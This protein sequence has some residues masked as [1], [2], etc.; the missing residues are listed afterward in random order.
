MKKFFIAF[1]MVG[2][3]A[4]ANFLTDWIGEILNME[5]NKSGNTFTFDQKK[6]KTQYSGTIIWGAE[7]Q[8]HNESNPVR[9]TAVE[10]FGDG[11]SYTTVT[12][13]K[14]YFLIPVRADKPFSIRASNGDEWATY[15]GTIEGV[16][17]GTIGTK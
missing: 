12:D 10:V 16:P 8:D 6:V 5:L 7:W 11:W 3:L 14:G 2:S 4:Q 1:L 15:N 9:G 17:K 13:D